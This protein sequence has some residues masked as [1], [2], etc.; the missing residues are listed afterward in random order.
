MSQNDLVLIHSATVPAGKRS[1]HNSDDNAAAAYAEAIATS[2]AKS[3]ANKG[4][5]ESAKRRIQEAMVAL[6]KTQV[7]LEAMNA[8]IGTFALL[9]SVMFIEKNH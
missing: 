1:R 3:Q 9:L 2:K 6:M 4:R 5:S 8:V 7:S